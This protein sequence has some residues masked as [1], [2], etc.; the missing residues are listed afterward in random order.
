MGSKELR[1]KNV[2]P[3]A[4]EACDLVNLTVFN[5]F[6]LSTLYFTITEILEYVYFRKPTYIL[7][8]LGKKHIHTQTHTQ[9]ISF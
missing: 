6:C 5:P 2:D 7:S 9:L 4:A 3:P 1:D 8:I